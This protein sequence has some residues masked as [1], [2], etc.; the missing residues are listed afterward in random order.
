MVASHRAK[1]EKSGDFAL[2]RE[3]SGKLGKVSEIVVCLCCAA[4]VAIVTK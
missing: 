1:L 2:V 4:T 3:K